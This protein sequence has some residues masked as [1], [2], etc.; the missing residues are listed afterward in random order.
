MLLSDVHVCQQQAERSCWIAS[1]LVPIV[2]ACSGVLHAQRPTV[3]SSM[4]S[5]YSWQTNAGFGHAGGT[6]LPDAGD[7]QRQ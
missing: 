1:L 6:L 3:S 2:M 5:M 7:W 4:D